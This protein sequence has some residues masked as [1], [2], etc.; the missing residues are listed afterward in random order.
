MSKTSIAKPRELTGR[1]VLIWIL[2]FFGLVFVVNG[3]LVQAATSTFGGLETASSY[4]AGLMFKDDMASAERQANLH[5]KVDGKLTRDKSGEAMLDVTVRDDKGAPVTG[6][7]GTARLAHPATSRL[8]HDVT[9]SALGAGA[10]HGEVA[11]PAGQWEL[12]IDLNRDGE[13]VFLSRSRV[14]LR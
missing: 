6:L 8:D 4:K 11:A 2:G 5:W 3:V 12:V 14:T 1:A 10:L 13:R 7:S 9:L